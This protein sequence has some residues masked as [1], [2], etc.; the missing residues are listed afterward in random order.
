MLQHTRFPIGNEVD[1]GVNG[2]LLGRPDSNGF[3]DEVNA[4]FGGWCTGGFL[5]KQLLVHTQSH[6]ILGIYKPTIVE[7]N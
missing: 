7:N 6:I 1:G 3:W 2:W 4:H 5:N